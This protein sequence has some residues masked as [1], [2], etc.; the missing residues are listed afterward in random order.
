MFLYRNTIFYTSL[1]VHFIN[2]A[3]MVLT[4]YIRDENTFFEGKFISFIKITVM[5]NFLGQYFNH[6]MLSFKNNLFFYRI[7]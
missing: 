5:V 4:I 2:H 1:T 3:L 7:I 6:S